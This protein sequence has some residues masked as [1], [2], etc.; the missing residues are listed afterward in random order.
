VVASKFATEYDV[1]PDDVW[2]L[3]C[4]PTCIGKSRFIRANGW[5]RCRFIDLMNDSFITETFLKNNAFFA[6]VT[7]MKILNFGSAELVLTS[8]PKHWPSGWFTEDYI[9]KLRAIVLGLPYEEWLKRLHRREKEPKPRRMFE[10]LTKNWVRDLKDINIPHIF[11]DSRNDYPII[12][13]SSFLKL[14]TPK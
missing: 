8:N 14:V 6:K 12:D 13:E 9:I 7:V 3:I 4:G 1:G 10:N 5:H 2:F 11:V